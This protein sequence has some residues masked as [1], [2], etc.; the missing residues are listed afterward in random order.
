MRIIAL[1]TCHNRRALT[2]SCLERLLHQGLPTE[3][4]LSVI[5]VDDG[6]SDG[7]ADA[8]RESFPE[9]RV[10]RGPGNLYWCGG[11]RVAWKEAVVSD[12]DYY[13]LVNDDTLIVDNAV[14]K[15]LELAGAPSERVIAVA[16][17]ADDTS[18]EVNYGAV[19]LKAGLLAPSDKADCDTFNANCVIVTRKV[20]QELGIFH[21]SYTH[22]MGDTDYGI[23]ARRQGIAIR[24]SDSF[25][26]TCGSNAVTLTWRDSSLPRR[27]R[28]QLLQQPK[29]LPFR[30]WIVF[31]RRNYRWRW[32]YYTFSPILR[33]L[34]GK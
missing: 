3:A 33:I 2:L 26:G 34:A 27:K 20:Y 23:Q 1:L 29:G 4:S 12:P 19:N 9:V 31:C 30:E 21:A 24:K 11:M 17:I 8:V 16:T 15:L 13:L 14:K 28:L 5:L 7:T 18:G 6:S 25:L 10:M 32:P 22:A